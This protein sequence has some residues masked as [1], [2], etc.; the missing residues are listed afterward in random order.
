MD[1]KSSDEQRPPSRPAPVAVRLAKRGDSGRRSV[2]QSSR[3][4]GE[5]IVN[6][7]T[8]KHLA[9][10]TRLAPVVA[11]DMAARQAPPPASQSQSQSE[12]KEVD[13][14]A[15]FAEQLGLSEWEAEWMWGDKDK[16]I[17]DGIASGEITSSLKQPSPE[18]K[19]ERDRERRRRRGRRSTVAE[20]RSSRAPPTAR[21]QK[22]SWL[23]PRVGRVRASSRASHRR[24]SRARG[25]PRLDRPRRAGRQGRRTTPASRP[26][27]PTSP[28]R[29]ATA[30]RGGYPSTGM[31]T[32]RPLHV[33]HR[34]GSRAAGPGRSASPPSR[35]S[36]PQPRPRTTAHRRRRRRWTQLAPAPHRRS[37]HEFSSARAP[38][39]AAVRGSV[40][41]TP[42]AA[43][44]RPAC[45]RCNG[46]VYRVE[47]TPPRGERRG[48]TFGTA[49]STASSSTAKPPAPRG[50]GRSP[51]SVAPSNRQSTGPQAA[52]PAAP[53]S[54]STPSSAPPPPTTDS[55]GRV[56]VVQR[57]ARCFTG[58][59][60][61]ASPPRER[62][63]LGR[64]ART[65]SE[66]V[67]GIRAGRVTHLRSQHVGRA[68]AGRVARLS[69]ALVGR[70]RARRVTRRSAELA[71]RVHAKRITRLRTERA[72]RA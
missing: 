34:R 29:A 15:A 5:S 37:A 2:A 13:H 36:L 49:E 54:S 41:G 1:E 42:T 31:T 8:P 40:V 47:H 6:A 66:L 9:A 17:A 44:S 4:I 70:R 38:P 11:R 53:R 62:E 60:S 21:C 68:H 45:G 51:A 18:V 52:R 10:S 16:A 35:P 39:S 28:P 55:V 72:G 65:G 25:S 67:A 64:V 24:R 48:R 61:R 43:A 57:A 71:G 33:G 20:R 56:G 63:A 3:R 46:A 19:R 23:R 12:E 50:A 7:R 32:T 30:P 59:T 22:A 69:A 27:R 58:S 26:P 14:Y